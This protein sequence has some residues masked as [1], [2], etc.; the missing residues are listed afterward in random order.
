MRLPILALAL[1]SVLAAGCEANWFSARVEA[2][3]VCLTDMPIAF[4]PGTEGASF[5]TALSEAD[6]GFTV[7]DSLEL[8]VAIGSVA[9]TPDAGITDF[10]F[11]ET[12]GVGIGAPDESL[13]TV[14]I[15]ELAS[16]DIRA[17]GV[18]YAEPTEPVDVSAYIESGQVMF[19]FDIAGDLP[20]QFWAAKMELCLDVAATYAAG[21]GE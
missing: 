6:L 7:S 4:P 1:A 14:A 2:S 5:E 9:L 12:I 10:D 17:D 19:S 21:F 13:P 8:E 3:E 16:A 11:L 18:L 15:I 20:E